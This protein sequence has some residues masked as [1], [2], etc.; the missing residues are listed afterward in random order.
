MVS[1]CDEN[2]DEKKFGGPMK[3][4]CQRYDRFWMMGL[5]FFVSVV[6]MV[7]PD[8]VHADDIEKQ[9]VDAVKT[10]SD[11]I[12]WT[13]VFASLFVIGLAWAVLRFLSSVIE[14]LGAAFVEY[15]LVFQKFGAFLRLAIY[16][17]TIAVCILMSFQISRDVLVVLGGTSAVALGFATRDLVASLLAG[18]MVIFDRPFQ[19]GDRVR[20]GGEYGDVVSIGLR[21]VKIRSLDDNIVTVPN[22]ML[23][24][25]VTSCGNYGV[26]N[27][28]VVVD[29]LVGADQDAE[30][31]RGLVRE[32]AVTSRFIHLPKPIV[33]Q[34]KQEMVGDY[35]ALRLR[36]KAYVLDTQY[37]K[38]FETD[39]TLRVLEAF[40]QNA[41][42][43][44]AILHREE[45]GDRLAQDASEAG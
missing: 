45:G 3:V 24:N 1:R 27:M 4:H 34:V 26:L 25:E 41:I 5:A 12:R 21:S 33:V 40:R 37:E 23:L 36:L 15:R 35:L 6:A 9:S 22:N 29:F 11:M 2:F 20:L 16:V 17:G 44:P 13:G 14:K 8:L 39:V 28:Q 7:L 19:V 31:A 43:M 18:M 10:L 32:A 30:I 38:E 42:R